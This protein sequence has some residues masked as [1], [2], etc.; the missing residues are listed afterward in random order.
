METPYEI[1]Y[2]FKPTDDIRKLVYS[3][4]E[5]ILMTAPS[6]A[7]LQVSV[8]LHKKLYKINFLMASKVK[9]IH[10]D[11]VGKNLLQSIGELQTTVHKSLK[12]W[13]KTRNFS[14]E[15]LA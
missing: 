1:T 9:T 3:N 13:K 2:N 12:D 5:K 10:K 7:F 6:D 4:V 15:A 14:N 11:I 8:A